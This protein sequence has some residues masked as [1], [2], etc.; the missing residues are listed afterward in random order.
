MPSFL[1]IDD[2]ASPDRIALALTLI[3]SSKAVSFPG[4]ALTVLDGVLH[5]D[6]DYPDLGPDDD[7]AHALVARAL[8]N[9]DSLLTSEP[10]YAAALSGLPRQIALVWSNGKGEVEIAAFRDGALAWHV[11]RL[12]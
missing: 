12:A 11:S 4:F 2:D 7:R 8:L 6:V 5:I 9:T 1:Q 10:T 3:L